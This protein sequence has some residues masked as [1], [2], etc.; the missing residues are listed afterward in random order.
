[1]PDGPLHESLGSYILSTLVFLGFC[2]ESSRM[3]L[4]TGKGEKKET[5]L[6]S[7]SCTSIWVFQFCIFFLDLSLVVVMVIFLEHF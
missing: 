3:T 6:R 2:R 7:L 4:T 5:G 1:M